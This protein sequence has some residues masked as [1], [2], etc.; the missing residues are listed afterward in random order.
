MSNR[1][2]WTSGTQF[3]SSMTGP[4]PDQPYTFVQFIGLEFVRGANAVPTAKGGSLEISHVGGIETDMIGLAV[5]EQ[6]HFELG[7][8]Y[9]VF[10]PGGERA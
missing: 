8:R 5:S 3:I 1:L 9:L 6:P 4:G 2:V 7:K 10:L